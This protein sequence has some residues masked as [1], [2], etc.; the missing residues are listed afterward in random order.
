VLVSAGPHFFMAKRAGHGSVTS[1]ALRSSNSVAGVDPRSIWSR[2]ALNFT[3]WLAQDADPLAEALEIEL[4]VEITEYA[5]GGYSLDVFGKDQRTYASAL[6]VV[7][8]TMLR[9]PC[10]C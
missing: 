2:K 7:N 4:E 10:N 3:P 5:V 9:N 8:W 6:A 1:T